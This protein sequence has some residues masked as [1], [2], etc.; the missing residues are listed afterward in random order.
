[1]WMSAMRRLPLMLVPLALAAALLASCS[2]DNVDPAAAATVKADRVEAKDNRF[3]PVA[4]EV[5]AGTTVT[6]SFEDGGTPHDVTGDGWK[7]GEPQSEGSYSHAFDRPGT[8]PYRCTL[9][10]GMDGRVVVTGS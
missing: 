1:M 7:S 3:D 2:A 10:A 8:Y 5:P 9:H 4:V 6:W